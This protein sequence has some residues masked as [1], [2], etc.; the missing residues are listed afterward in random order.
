MPKLKP[1][2]MER[3][4]GRIVA[5]ARACFMRHG[6]SDCSMDDICAEA[7]LSKG[8]V[9]NHFTSKEALIHA[10]AEAQGRSLQRL[11]EG[12]SL[13]EIAAALLELFHRPTGPEARLEL[14]GMTRAFSDEALLARLRRNCALLQAALAQALARLEAEGRVRLRA[15]AEAAAEILLTFLQGVIARQILAPD[16][17]VRGEFNLLVGLMV[18]KVR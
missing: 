9:Y 8:A 16:M 17:D 15:D 13:E 7:G 4:R 11:S 3:R 1:D 14:E 2:E 5:A 6:F 10:V 18:E 12:E